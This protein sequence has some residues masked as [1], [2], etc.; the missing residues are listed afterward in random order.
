M[1]IACSALEMPLVTNHPNRLPFVGLLGFVGLPSE[2]PPCGA[3][4]HCISITQKCA[5]GALPGMV[6]MSL[7]ADESL[8]K[9]DLHRKIGIITKAYVYGKRIIVRG[10]LYQEDWKE[11]IPSLRSSD[12]GMSV[13]IKDGHCL[14]MRA[15]VWE[16][17]RAWITGAAVM[18]REKAAYRNTRFWV[19]CR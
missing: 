13:D 2:K 11:L 15:E 12:M 3:R 17:D 18:K 1:K 4:G 14:D 9:H 16:I 8:N 7:Y 19:A 6:G 5:V 10:F